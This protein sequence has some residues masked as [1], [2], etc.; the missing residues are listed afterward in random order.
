MSSHKYQRCDNGSDRFLLS[1]SSKNRCFQAM[2]C[3]ERRL[4]KLSVQSPV[5]GMCQEI[6][7]RVKHVR[8]RLNILHSF[9][10]AWRR[11]RRVLPF[12]LIDWRKWE[13][14]SSRSSMF[15]ERFSSNVFTRLSPVDA[16]SISIDTRLSLLVIPAECR[17]S[18]CVMS[19][20]STRRD[21]WTFK[22][23]CSTKKTSTTNVNT[24]KHNFSLR[25]TRNLS[26]LRT[27]T[28]NDSRTNLCCQLPSD[29]SGI[30]FIPLSQFNQVSSV[31]TSVRSVMKVLILP[32][33]HSEGFSQLWWSLQCAA[34][35]SIGWREID[36]RWGEEIIPNCHSFSQHETSRTIVALLPIRQMSISIRSSLF[37]PDHFQM[38]IFIHPVRDWRCIDQDRKRNDRAPMMI[39]LEESWYLNTCEI[40]LFSNREK[41]T[42]LLLAHE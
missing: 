26:R 2:N 10:F 32:L 35:V 12:G 8:E 16:F 37:H 17:S 23:R 13:V 42:T 24:R 28:I 39:Y 31:S 40:V 36:V 19:L 3:F 22:W 41:C 29:L 33:W 25:R 15:V 11:S 27:C 4:S 5:G 38:I 6:S 1:S 18:M 14:S 20:W 9:L 7:W 21:R 34:R 30:R